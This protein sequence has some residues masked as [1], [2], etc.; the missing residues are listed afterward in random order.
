MNIP[1]S[2]N[3]SGSHIR[4]WVAVFIFAAFAASSWLVL[5]AAIPQVASGTWVAAGEVGATP[6][7]ATSVALADG[8]VLVAGG[9]SG[10]VFSTLIST[11]NPASG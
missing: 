1:S 5:R 2:F 8:R 7:G 11:Y 4:S 3:R 9:K 6:A 10:G